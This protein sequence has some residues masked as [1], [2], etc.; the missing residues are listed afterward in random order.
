MNVFTRMFSLAV[1]NAAECETYIREV[2]KSYPQYS[3]TQVLNACREMC[4]RHPDASIDTL[5]YLYEACGRGQ[6][7]RYTT[8]LEEIIQEQ[9]EHTI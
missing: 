8:Q 4:A 2:H 7:S 9:Q 1:R 3:Y 6:P 5:Q